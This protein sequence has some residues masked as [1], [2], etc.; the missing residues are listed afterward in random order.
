MT[1]RINDESN[2]RRSFLKTAML[3]TAAVGAGV[4]LLDVIARGD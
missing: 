1:K 2:N 3:G 4:V